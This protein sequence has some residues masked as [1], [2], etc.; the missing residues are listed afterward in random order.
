MSG[1]NQ[2]FERGTVKYDAGKRRHALLPDELLEGVIDVLMLGESRY[3]AWNWTK[4]GE[5]NGWSRYYDSLKRHL[6]AFW[7]GEDIDP[8][9]QLHHL[10]HLIANA[11][12]LRYYTRRWPELDDRPELFPSDVL[13]GEVIQIDLKPGMSPAEALREAGYEYH[14]GRLAKRAI[15]PTPK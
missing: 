4:G 1:W 15:S 2:D 9:S 11:I 13:P 7:K 10:D 14:D 5:G 6:N 3:G 8:D 12:F